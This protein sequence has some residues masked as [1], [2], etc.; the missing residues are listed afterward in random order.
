M[1]RDGT[2]STGR[3]MAG[4]GAVPSPTTFGRM[5][6]RDLGIS[7][8]PTLKTDTALLNAQQAAEGQWNAGGNWNAAVNN[9]PFNIELATAQAKAIGAPLPTG[10]HNSSPSN[11]ISI[12]GTQAQGANATAD[13]ISAN[14]PVMASALHTGNASSFLSPAGVGQWAAHGNTTADLAAQSAYSTAVAAQYGKP[15]KVSVTSPNGPGSIA[16]STSTSTSSSTPNFFSALGTKVGY[17]AAGLGILLI[18]LIVL[19]HDKGGNTTVVGGGAGESTATDASVATDAA[20]A[21]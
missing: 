15:V 6:L 1:A 10:V 5:V 18:G 12:F 20:V 21:A 19:F 8:G 4:R 7:K 2:Q 14:D 13:F 11:P 9:N 16:P 17:Y 3:L